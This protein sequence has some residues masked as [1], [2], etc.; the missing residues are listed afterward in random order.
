MKTSPFFHCSI[1]RRF[2]T[3]PN[4]V[5]LIAILLM[6][7]GLHGSS[8]ETVLEEA[9]SKNFS[10]STRRNFCKMA[11]AAIATTAFLG[12][13]TLS[14]YA[15]SQPSSA[16]MIQNTASGTGIN[17]VLVHGSFV[18]ASSWSQ[19]ISVLQPRQYNALAVQL[20]LTSLADDVAVT[21][22]ALAS[23]SGPTIL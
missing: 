14:A 8:T 2:A 15:S 3:L 6:I 1:L 18:D 9:M 5:I 12:R 22:Q 13:P 10:Q 11:G 21:R 17:I 4:V 23:L 16:E 19:A 20:P 7:A